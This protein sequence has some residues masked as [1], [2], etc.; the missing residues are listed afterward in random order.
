MTDFWV[1]NQYLYSV[2]E[3]EDHKSVSFV[4]GF[5]PGTPGTGVLCSTPSRGNSVTDSNFEL[6]FKYK[7]VMNSENHTPDVAL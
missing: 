7:T 6:L 2:V 1:P 5:K 3:C 4:T